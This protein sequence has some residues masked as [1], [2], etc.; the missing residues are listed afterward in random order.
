MK[1]YPD[2]PFI[3]TSS[4]TRPTIAENTMTVEVVVP[5]AAVGSISGENNIDFARL[6]QVNGYAIKIVQQLRLSNAAYCFL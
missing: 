4:G 5:E 2:I 6:R 1:Y 3:Y